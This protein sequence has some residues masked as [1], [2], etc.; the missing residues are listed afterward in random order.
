MDC[1]S[2]FWPCFVPLCV[3]TTKDRQ[4]RGYLRPAADVVATNL[5]D[6][7]MVKPV[8]LN[9]PKLGGVDVDPGMARCRRSCSSTGGLSANPPK[10]G[11]VT[12]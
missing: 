8:S 10:G 2:G 5:R 9:L 4:V 7:E 3:A 12:C 11:I 1:W 6:I